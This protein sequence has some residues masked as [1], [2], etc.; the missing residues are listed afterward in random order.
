MTADERIAA[1]QR[2]VDGMAA[3]LRTLAY[4]YADLSQRVQRMEARAGRGDA[5]RP[6]MAV[7]RLEVTCES[8]DFDGGTCAADEMPL[9]RTIPTVERF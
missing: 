5:R 7:S 4:Q 3:A 6:T 2:Q 9:R 1:L 8:R